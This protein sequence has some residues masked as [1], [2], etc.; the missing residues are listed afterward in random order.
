MRSR[1]PTQRA[2][3]TDVRDGSRAASA[4]LAPWPAWAGI[5]GPVLFTATFLAQEP[6]RRDEYSPIAERSARWRPGRTVGSSR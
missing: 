4:A 6:F 5:V 1:T 3:T 2:A